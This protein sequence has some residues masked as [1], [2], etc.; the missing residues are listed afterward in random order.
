M[1]QV[2]IADGQIVVSDDAP[3]IV[4]DIENIRRSLPV[5][6]WGQV[7]VYLFS[8]H[9]GFSVD[10]P[11]DY[12]SYKSNILTLTQTEYYVRLILSKADYQPLACIT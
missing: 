9:T 1:S 10:V 7:P 3:S 6:Q 5:A 4:Y 11:H 12:G 8:S 2:P